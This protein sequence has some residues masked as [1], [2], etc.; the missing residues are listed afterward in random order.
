MK[1][2]VMCNIYGNW[3]GFEGSQKTEIGAS[4]YRATIWLS[5]RLLKG[6]C[7]LSDKSDITMAD[8]EAYRVRDAEQDAYYAKRNRNREG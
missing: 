5:E 4:Q 1:V 2:K 6:D 3:N 7:T 8:I